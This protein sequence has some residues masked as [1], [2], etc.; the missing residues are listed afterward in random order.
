MANIIR[1]RGGEKLKEEE[2][3]MAII[4]TNGTR[5]IALTNSGAVKKVDDI[6][7]AYNFYSVEKAIK[8]KNKAPKKCAGYYFIDTDINEAQEI[9][10]DSTLNRPMVKRK[11]F[12]AKERLAIYRKTKGHCYLCGE[13]VDYDFFEVEHKVPLSKGGTNDLSNVFCACHCCNTIKHDI[14]PQDFLEKISQIFIYQMSIHNR[15]SLKWKII[16]KELQKMC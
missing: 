7:K 10:E 4:L 12:S 1:K 9:E 6:K 13:F 14:Y 2:T 11:N 15:N 5:Y 8:Q 3:I 16:H